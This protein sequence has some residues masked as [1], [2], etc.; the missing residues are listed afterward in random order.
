MLYSDIRNRIVYH[1]EQD[2]KVS[3]WNIQVFLIIVS[4]KEEFGFYI[5]AEVIEGCNRTVFVTDY[6]VIGFVYLQVYLP[7]TDIFR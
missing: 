1:L 7:E 2:L 3:I 6:I 5:P 4:E